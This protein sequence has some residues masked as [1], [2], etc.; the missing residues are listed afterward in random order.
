MFV[1]I[2]G[3]YARQQMYKN[4][5]DYEH[6]MSVSHILF[7]NASEILPPGSFV[8][9]PKVTTDSTSL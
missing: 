5:S 8:P 1:G 3:E 7:F 2:Q 6:F 9:P 4:V